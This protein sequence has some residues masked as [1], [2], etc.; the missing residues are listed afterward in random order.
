MS[1]RQERVAGIGD[2]SG[3]DHEQAFADINERFENMLKGAEVWNERKPED[4]NADLGARANDFLTG[5]VRLLKD[6]NTARAEEKAPHLEAGRAVDA[7]WKPLIDKIDKLSDIVRPLLK[8]LLQRE[9]RERA[10][11]ERK[12]RADAAAAAE[13]ERKARLEAEQANTVS[14]KLA[15]A[16]RAD[17]AAEQAKLANAT[18]TA[19]SGAARVSS[20]TGAAT[21]RSLRTIRKPQIVSLA[22]ALAHYKGDPAVAD[23]I[24]QLAARDLR[25]AP[26]VRG[27]KQLPEIPGVEWIETQ[28]V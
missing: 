22:S 21:R 15:A 23:L 6:A 20:A 4:M 3:A 25:E 12:A 24:L 14:E 19:N 2:N 27:V 17:E 1:E 10:D 7:K 18:A 13:A 8:A 16:E 11:A 5:A 26:T 9:A 28:E